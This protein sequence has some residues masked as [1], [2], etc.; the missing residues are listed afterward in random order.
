MITLGPEP[1]GLL[2]KRAD[3]LAWLPGLSREAWKKLSAT[4][5]KRY[6]PGGAKPA[7]PGQ[8]PMYIK[9]EIRAKLVAP[10]QAE[11]GRN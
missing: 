8:R 6:V 9:E 5:A 1:D 3:V 7:Y 2:L 11:A 4:L 10:M